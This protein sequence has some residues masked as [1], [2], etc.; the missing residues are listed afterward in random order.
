MAKQK[1]RVWWIP[2]VPG[3]PFHVDVTNLVEAKLILN[4]LAHYDL[5]QYENYI[6]GDY[7]NAGG[8]EVWDEADQEW[9]NWEDE[10][11]G[12]EI[13]G[14]TLKELRETAAIKLFTES[15]RQ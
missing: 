11:S 15:H 7:A 6:K 8:L 14:Y 13:D 1:I 4:T 5:F 12:R 9:T 10:D 3:R 2:Q